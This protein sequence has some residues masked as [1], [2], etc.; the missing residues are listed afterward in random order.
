[1]QRPWVPVDDRS[2]MHIFAYGPAPISRYPDAKTAVA[3][4]TY[5]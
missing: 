3:T 5:V 1:M 4:K 2:W